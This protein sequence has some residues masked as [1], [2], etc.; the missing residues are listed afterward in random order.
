MEGEFFECELACPL[1]SSSS[2]ALPPSSRQAQLEK[3]DYSVLNCCDPRP[4]LKEEEEEG[5]IF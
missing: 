4:M 5:F 3:A 1:R 2:E